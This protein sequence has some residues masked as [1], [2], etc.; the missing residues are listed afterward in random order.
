LP[1][2]QRRIT[3]A[4]GAV[5]CCYLGAGALLAAGSLTLHLPAAIAAQ[6][7]LA[8]GVAGLP[9]A[10]LG[11]G[12]APN[13]VLAAV[14]YLT[15]PGFGI[16]DHTRISVLATS[17]GR[18][19][20]FPLLA[21]LPTGGPAP[22]LG[23]LAIAAVAA[24]AGWLCMRM[25]RAP[26]GWP[27]R[28]VDVAAA[29]ALAGGSLAVLTGFAAGGVG[30]G[31]LS[32][33]GARWWAVGG[34]GFLLVLVSSGAWLAVDLLR[35]GP[36]VA[37]PVRTRLRAVAGTTENSPTAERGMTQRGPTAGATARGRTPAASRTTAKDGDSRSR[38][39][40]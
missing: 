19:P 28:L 6:R 29:A 2:R 37:E 8:P 34:C 15:G 26:G 24:L 4:G 20:R 35:L 22:V 7:Q 1:E 23:L 5:L 3:R 39:V 17:H 12:L 10:L 31:A 32:G 38:N 30:S 27:A 25:L 11:I 36:V 14:G 9:I 16:G 13:A 18:L 33:I 21:A 40:G